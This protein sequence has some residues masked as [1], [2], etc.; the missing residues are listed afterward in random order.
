MMTYQYY[1][2]SML[3]HRLENTAVSFADMRRRHAQREIG[4]VRVI[5][6]AKTGG[7]CFYCG[8]EKKL[9]PDHW[10]PIAR[11]GSDGIGNLFPC[12]LGCNN[13]KKDLLLEEWRRA[14]RLKLARENFG[15][16]NFSQTQCAWL[17]QA[18]FNVLNHLGVPPI[19]FWFETQGIE[20]PVGETIE[21]AATGNERDWADER[22][23]SSRRTDVAMFC[24]EN[25]IKIS[26]AIERL[27]EIDTSE[28][29]IRDL[30]ARAIEYRAVSLSSTTNTTLDEQER[31]Q[32]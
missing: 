19:S 24:E 17:E 15:M 20:T 16:P 27:M 26:T 25:E 22:I 28:E 1:M 29:V 21:W 8:E 11:G 32:A 23:A 13:S 10:I 30:N 2:F 3:K 9:V 31:A 18:G 5:V 7:L 14:R 12:C 6:A 4:K